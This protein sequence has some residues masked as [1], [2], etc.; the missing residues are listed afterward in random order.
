[1]ISPSDRFLTAVTL[2][3]LIWT[4][5]DGWCN[6]EKQERERRV[7][8]TPLQNIDGRSLNVFNLC[9]LNRSS[10][11]CWPPCARP[12]E[13]RE[14]NY[15]CLSGN[16]KSVSPARTLRT[17]TESLACNPQTL[18]SLDL[19]LHAP[20]PAVIWMSRLTAVFLKTAVFWFFALFYSL[21]EHIVPPD[22]RV[23]L[24]LVVLAGVTCTG[25]VVGFK[26]LGKNAC[27]FFSCLKCFLFGMV[28]VLRLQNKLTKPGTCCITRVYV[29]WRICPLC[30]WMQITQIRRPV[31]PRLLA[32]RVSYLF[33][34]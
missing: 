17:E 22:N 5:L 18:I 3:G 10:R 6:A 14:S 26:V 25:S 31:T 23:L 32:P 15:C 28:N 2:S 16:G 13:C 20:R 24:A 1:M 34:V 12:P 19:P 27:K 30:L 33:L 8:P 7:V 11:I 9:T 4:A 29:C 21:G